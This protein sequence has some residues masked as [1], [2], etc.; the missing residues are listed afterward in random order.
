M[1][2]DRK[3][4]RL[5]PTADT[6][7]LYDGKGLVL[8]VP[9][10]GASMWRFDFRLNGKRRSM[11]LGT[12]PDVTLAKARQ[13]L[14]EA[15]AL[16]ADGIDP[17]A[18][19]RAERV[20]ERTSDDFRTLADE[21]FKV[22]TPILAPHTRTKKRWLLDSFILPALGRMAVKDIKPI[23]ALE[24]LRGIERKKLHD[25]TLR[26]RQVTS[27]IFRYGIALD[28]VES[29]VTR[30]L[31][32]ALTTVPAKHRAALTAP[33]PVGALLR[34]I[35]TLDSVP[36]RCALQ[37][38]ALTFVRPGELRLAEWSEVDKTEWRIPARRTKQRQEH[39][40]PLSRQARQVFATLR[41]VSRGSRYVIPTTRTITAPLSEMAF[42]A[43][44]ARLGYGSDT[45]TPH[46]FR[47]MARTLLDE[48]LHQTPEVIEAQLAHVTPGPLGATY[49]R[50]R[51]LPQ[52]A[53]LMQVYA[54]YLDT[55]RGKPSVMPFRKAK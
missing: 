48:Q 43:A 50:S 36:L 11:S 15:R 7:R 23:H 29:D 55:L 37:L 19:R 20:A 25:T 18:S 54:D 45:M 10:T 2:T 1:L 17:V 16:V 33:K 3:L 44:L 30:D 34:A 21:W 27:E 35:D 49:N 52:R 8:I 39:I 6:Q 32:G 24:M 31:I 13:K 38:L 4:T 14:T 40:V 47:A 26:A 22:R 5:K 9:P 28:R 12:Y 42:L 53:V 51:Y 41:T 46:G